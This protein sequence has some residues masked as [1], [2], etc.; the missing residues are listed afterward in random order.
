MILYYKIVYIKANH[1]ALNISL[2]HFMSLSPAL[3]EFSAAHENVYH[4]NP[5]KKSVFKILELITYLPFE[6]NVIHHTF[7]D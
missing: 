7:I 1:P 2:A 3:L 6:K 5:A 4:A